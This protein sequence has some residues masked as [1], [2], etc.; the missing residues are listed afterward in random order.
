MKHG[1]PVA[2]SNTTCLPE[3]LGNAALYFDP[4]KSR[5]IAKQVGRILENSKVR[6]ELI[7]RGTLQT[8]KYSW[9]RMAEQTLDVYNN[10]LDKSKG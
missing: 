1:A 8:K 2:S 10:A 9:K 3:V 6:P 4:A 5:D 7:Q